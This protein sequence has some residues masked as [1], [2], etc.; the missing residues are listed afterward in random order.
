MP[1]TQVLPVQA[2]AADPQVKELYQAI[3]GKM[4]MLPNIFKNMGNSATALKGFL[5]LSEAA[6]KTSLSSELKE[7]IA[8]TV[9]QANS[10]QYCLSAHTMLAKF[11]GIPEMEVMQARKATA[12]NPKDKAILT[13]AKS[14]V[15]KKGHIDKSELAGLKAAGVS[16]KEIVEIILVV[17]VNMFTNYF[18]LIT[19]TEIDFPAAPALN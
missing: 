6:G 9:G 19:G 16:D 10:C 7:K 17:M 1:N 4:H 14:I 18:N 15:D 2:N 3:E 5:D 12:T 13:F 11:T 8:L